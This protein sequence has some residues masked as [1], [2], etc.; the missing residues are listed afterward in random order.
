MPT[1]WHLPAKHSH[2]NIEQLRNRNQIRSRQLIRPREN[3]RCS[4]PGGQVKNTRKLLFTDMRM[5]EQQPD[6]ACRG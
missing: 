4:H 1:D 6:P 2:R 3:I 5:L